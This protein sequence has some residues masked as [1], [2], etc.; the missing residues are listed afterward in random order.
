MSIHRIELC[1]AFL[2]PGPWS[3]CGAWSPL[4]VPGSE[5]KPSRATPGAWSV[6]WV[7]QSTFWKNGFDKGHYFCTPSFT[8]TLRPTNKRLNK[9]QIR[10]LIFITNI[11]IMMLIID[12]LISSFW[13]KRTQVTIPPI[14]GLKRVTRVPLH[15]KKN[16]TSAVGSYS[17]FFS[18]PMI[19]IPWESILQLPEQLSKVVLH[20][21]LLLIQSFKKYSVLVGF[22]FCAS[23]YFPSLPA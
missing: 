20:L 21:P 13:L 1:L 14:F 12:Y 6:P 8:I 15:E 5:M 10:L 4:C 2:Q 23:N 7:V 3:V 9:S 22:F 16:F 18:G 11:Y 17:T 19:K